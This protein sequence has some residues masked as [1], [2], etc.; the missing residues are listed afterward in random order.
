MQ[1]EIIQVI[2]YQILRQIASNIK[3]AGRFSSMMDETTDIFTEGANFFALYW[4][5][6]DW[7]IHEDFIG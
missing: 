7:S 1:N 3:A 4:I 6:D 2:G 5:D